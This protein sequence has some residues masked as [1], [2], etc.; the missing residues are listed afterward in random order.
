V[1]K[2]IIYSL[3]SFIIL[4]SALKNP[5]VLVGYLFNRPVRLDFK[6]GIS[7]MTSH[8]LEAIVAKETI[9]DDDYRLRL[10]QPT[11]IQPG[12]LIL[13]VGAGVGDWAVFAASK[14]PGAKIVA[15]EPNPDQYRLLQ[16]NIKLNQ[17]KNIIAYN[18]AVGTKKNYYLSVPSS[19]VHASTMKIDK[20]GKRMTV[21]GRRLDSFIAGPVDL[22]KIDCE[23]AEIDILKSISAEKMKL[24]GRFLIEYHNQII[25]DE[26]KKILILLKK[27]RYRTKQIK[28][29]IVPQT[30]YIFANL[31]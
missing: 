18:L 30:G 9:I 7:L 5:L 29:P 26:D 1:I 10:L 17:V 22:V 3:K 4:A 15:I 14:F 19:S 27:Y 13:D 28:N 23:G 6:L 20:P 2:K 11:D 21:A 12:R 31:S 8:W 25:A 24:I 16:L